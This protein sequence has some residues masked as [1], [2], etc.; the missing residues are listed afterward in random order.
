M[1]PR[2]L[3]GATGQ[4][5]MGALLAIAVCC[6]IPFVGFAFLSLAG[7]RLPPHRIGQV[8]NPGTRSKKSPA[9]DHDE[10]GLRRSDA[11]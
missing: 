3:R 7:K 11:E 9:V 4:G 2:Q 6:A 8:R 10:R 5:M 1:G